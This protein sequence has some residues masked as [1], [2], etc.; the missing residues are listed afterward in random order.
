LASAAFY[1]NKK[2]G[3]PMEYD[4]LKLILTDGVIMNIA[5]LW[6]LVPWNEHKKYWEE[7]QEGKYDWSHIAYQLWPERVKKACKKNRS[8]AIAHGLVGSR[9]WT[10]I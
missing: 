1:G 2:A 10:E 6:E 3:D 4:Y 8:I 9:Q 5:P 7:L